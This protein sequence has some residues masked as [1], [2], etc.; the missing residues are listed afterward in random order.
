MEIDN[1]YNWT[2][3][4]TEAESAIWIAYRELISVL[5]TVLNPV[6]RMDFQKIKDTMIDVEYFWLN[7]ENLYNI[8]S[9]KE[10][11]SNE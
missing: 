1:K 2:Y 7:P 9:D 6:V 5:C 4:L 11:E 8:N 3:K 10:D